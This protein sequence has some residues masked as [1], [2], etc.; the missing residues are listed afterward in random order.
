MLWR[1]L[2]RWAALGSLGVLCALGSARA[3]E[4]SESI[5]LNTSS[6][7]STDTAA[8]E[9]QADPV[10]VDPKIKAAVDAALKA[11]DAAEKKKA[12]EKKLKEQCD[13]Y[14]VG[15]ELGGL[16][17]FW[18]PANGVNCESA[19]KDFRL[20]IGGRFQDDVVFWDEPGKLRGPGGVGT[21]EDG[22]FFRRIRLNLDGV[23]WEQMEFNMEYAFENFGNNTGIGEL[24]EF[25]V[26]IKD[27]PLLGTIRI[28]HLKVPQ[29]LEGDMVSSS[30]DMTFMERAS[31]TDAFY[32]NFA[33]GIWFGNHILD[34]HATWSY[35][36]YKQ[37]QGTIS[38]GAGFP[39]AGAPNGAAIVDNNWGQSARFTFLPM[40]ANEGRCLMHLG[41]SETYR[42][43]LFP[44]PGG[45][46]TNSGGNTI[47][48]FSARPE[49]RDTIGNYTNVGP[50][51]S[52]RFVDTGALSCNDT[53]VTGFE[54]LGISGPL[55][56]QAEWGI[57]VATSVSA[58]GAVAIPKQNLAFDGGYLQ[59]SYILTGESRGYDRRLGRLQTNGIRPYTPFFLVRDRD[60]GFCT[61]LGAIE[62]AARYSY[63]NLN[64]GPVQGGVLGSMS[65]GVNWYL[66]NNLKMQFEFLNTNRWNIGAASPAGSVSGAVNSFGI[67]TQILF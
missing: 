45:G 37:E 8:A 3:D 50:G 43:A 24:D 49:M 47:V 20:H 15:S 38:G 55:T 25:W 4:P 14:P 19:H 36:M 10:V 61:G 40:Y 29:G 44:Q 46:V 12:E 67:R 28:G 31:Y 2:R 53:S 34:D 54:F 52:R 35:M 63:L 65:Y 18:D 51:N 23:A 17:V 5:D 56:V 30:K 41:V 11:R 39:G 26:G 62:L 22:T 42:S 33:P 60:G 9:E 64:D 48:D 21:L 57:A 13:G 59:A 7:V 32:E 16:K 27:M 58:V 1:R 6:S 66:N